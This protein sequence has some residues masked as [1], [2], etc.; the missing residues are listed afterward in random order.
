MKDE[1]I[2]TYTAEIC[3][4]AEKLY[5][6][7]WQGKYISSQSDFKDWLNNKTSLNEDH[8]IYENKE[9]A[10]KA[11]MESLQAIESKA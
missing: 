3:R 6:D 4:I 1:N 10:L 7:E 11:W 5:P 9:A 8:R 2:K